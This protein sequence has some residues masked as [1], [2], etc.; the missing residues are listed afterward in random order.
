MIFATSLRL[1]GSSSLEFLITEGCLVHNPDPTF[2]TDQVVIP[3][4]I[5]KPS[6]ELIE[7]PEDNQEDHRKRNQSCISRHHLVAKIPP[8]FVKKIQGYIISVMPFL[9]SV[10]IQRA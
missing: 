8:P 9:F 1:Q 4:V 6:I 7:K 3:D 10:R 2:F 5:P